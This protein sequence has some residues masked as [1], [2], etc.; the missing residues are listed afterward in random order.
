MSVPVTGHGHGAVA[1]CGRSCPE[2]LQYQSGPA[3]VTHNGCRQGAARAVPADQFGTLLNSV[4][5]M[6]SQETDLPDAPGADSIHD[7]EA[8]RSQHSEEPDTQ[9]SRKR[10]RES[11]AGTRKRERVVNCIL[12]NAA[13]TPHGNA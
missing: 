10:Q 5:G 12:F 3:L 9:Q 13:R 1:A 8:P 11:E 2:Q 6:A 4:T 7:T